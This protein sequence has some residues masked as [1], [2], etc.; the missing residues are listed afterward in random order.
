MGHRLPEVG[1]GGVKSA[2]GGKIY[3]HRKKTKFCDKYNAKFEKE[4]RKWDLNQTNLK[5]NPNF[6]PEFLI[7]QERNFCYRKNIL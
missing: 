6:I 2:G 1:G 7:N 5:K 3:G 4:V